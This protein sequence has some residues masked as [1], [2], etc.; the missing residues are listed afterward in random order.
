MIPPRR[1]GPPKRHF[2]LS[3]T[4]HRVLAEINDG[5]VKTR[6]EE[7]FHNSSGRQLEGYYMFPLPDGAAASGFT[8][9]IAGKVV[10]GEVL[11]KDKAR[12]IYEGIVRRAKDPGLLEYVGRGLIRARVFPI[13]PRG[14]VEVSIEYVQEIR[15]QGGLY[16]YRYPLAPGKHS[17]GPYKDVAF[18]IKIDSSRPLRSINCLSHK[19]GIHRTG[20]LKARVGF[21]A[22]S[23]VQEGDFLLMWNVGEDALAPLCLVSRGHEEKGYFNIT[24]SPRVDAKKL[25]T[26]KDVVFV[27]DTSGSMRGHKMEQAKKALVYCIEGL[28][29]AD[30]FNVVD[31]SIEARRF[32]PGLV[33]IEGDA[34]SRGLAYARALESGSGTNLEEA[35]RFALG[36]LETPERLQMVVVLTDGMPTIGVTSPEKIMASIKKANSHNR[37][38]FVFGVGQNLNAKLLDRI[39]GE[40][41]GTS[42]YI[43][44]RENIELRLSAFYDKIDSPVLTNLRIEFPDGGVSDVF[45]RDM[46]DLFHGVQLSLFGRYQ[47]GQVGGGNKNRTVLL[48]GKYLGE[49]RTFEYSFDFSGKKG[50]GGDQ[51]SRLWASRKI[52]YLLEQIRLN[53]GS[54]E[55]KSEVVRLSKLHGI[56]TPYTSYLIVEEGALVEGNRPPPPG[57]PRPLGGAVRDALSASSKRGLSPGGR[58]LAEAKSAFDKDRGASAVESS[59]E[60]G[61]LKRSGLRQD[62]GEKEKSRSSGGPIISRVGSLTFYRQGKSWVD[63]RLTVKKVERPERKISWLSGEY[64]EFLKAN[65]KAGKILALGSS[66]TFLWEGEV[67]KVEAPQ[68]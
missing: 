53:G 44:D 30:R 5:L 15:P 66:V 21:E 29:D 57:S 65:P 32:A 36:D 35:M 38:M 42:E 13:P 14:D 17:M 26:P 63:S 28:N 7:T 58:S 60:I 6:V 49:E 22:A 20:E 25:A 2:P 23:L 10:K 8:M 1:P 19:V 46:P 37:R 45:P 62:L 9:K 11:D 41:R 33:A 67:V 31:F 40:T 34:R 54:G 18:D 48:R 52:G 43:R 64:F 55:L 27:I 4:R 3:I 47:P 61:R 39:A 24:L 12:S 56:I 68:S 16:L 51:L 59:R 50:P